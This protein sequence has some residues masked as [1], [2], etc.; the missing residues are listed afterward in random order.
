MILAGHCALRHIVLV[1]RWCVKL[2][3][4]L[5]IKMVYNLSCTLQGFA[6]CSRLS[7]CE[8]TRVFWDSLGGQ[9]NHTCISRNG[10]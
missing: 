4:R 9:N 8:D 7:V 2:C 10:M 3:C 1:G 6:S 5:S